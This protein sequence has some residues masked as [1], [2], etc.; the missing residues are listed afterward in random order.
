[1]TNRWRIWRDKFKI[2]FNI[3]FL[4]IVCVEVIFFVMPLE[5]ITNDSLNYCSICEILGNVLIR[6]NYSPQDI[7]DCT[8]IDSSNTT[9]KAVY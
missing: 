7:D 9:Q 5:K 8:C 1:M 4:I 6:F 3:I 2:W